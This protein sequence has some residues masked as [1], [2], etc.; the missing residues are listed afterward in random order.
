MT[1]TKKKEQSLES[2]E[3]VSNLTRERLDRSRTERQSWSTTVNSQDYQT[4]N[5]GKEK[6]RK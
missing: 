6:R 2:D 1:K 3:S 5:G 4:D